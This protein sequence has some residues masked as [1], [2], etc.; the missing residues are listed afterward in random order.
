MA[1]T[2]HSCASRIDRLSQRSRA[3]RRWLE[4]CRQNTGRRTRAPPARRAPHKAPA[5]AQGERG[6]AGAQGG[7]R[8]GGNRGAAPG[9][10]AGGPGLADAANVGG[11]YGPKPPVTA[12]SP[13]EEAKRF[14]LPPGYHL[15]LVLS[16]PDIVSPAVIAFDGNG[17]MYV[18]EFRSYMLDADA[19]HQHEP[20][21]RISMHES[22]KRDGKFDRHTVFADNLLA[23]RMILPL[24]NGILT[25]ETHSDDVLQLTDT[26]GDGVADK[27]QVFY[28]GVGNGAA[29][30][31]SSAERLRL[32]ARQL[33]LQHL[34]R[35]PLPL[36]AA[37]HP[38]RAARADQA[39]SGA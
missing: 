13:E 11:D 20:T 27:K 31:S 33:D 5:G 15:E 16:D 22:T 28:T 38:P 4:H 23:P 25:N 7:E 24:D 19:G 3:G 18:A 21:S 34:Q 8:G 6:A 9:G 35:V 1:D 12:L 10:R 30:T 37:R 39:A 32:G 26:N 14:I 36:D 2:Q 17:R 29:A